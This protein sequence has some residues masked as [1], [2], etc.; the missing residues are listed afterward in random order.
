MLPLYIK[1]EDTDGTLL[2]LELRDVLVYV[3]TRQP[4]PVQ[5]VVNPAG[6][7]VNVVYCLNIVVE[8]IDEEYVPAVHVVQTPLIMP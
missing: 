8:E 6:D 7:V 5:E 2:L 4:V 1:V 3:H